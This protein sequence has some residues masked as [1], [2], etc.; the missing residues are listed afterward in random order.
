MDMTVNPTRK[1]YKSRRNRFID[2]ICGGLAE[3]F[4]VDPTI[5][6]LLWVL[7]TFL[8][9]SGIILYIV[10]MIL[11]P[12]NPEHLVTPRPSDSSSTTPSSDRRRFFG[13]LLM[14]CGI[15]FLVINLG[16]FADFSW[17][18]F[19]RSVMLPIFLILIGGLFIYT[20]ST[21]Q[22]QPVSANQQNIGMDATTS[23][24]PKQKELR[25]SITD[26]KLFGVCGGLAKYFNVDATI[27]RLVFV[28]MVLGSFG[29]ALLLY[30]IL[31]I[32]VQ[33]EKPTFTSL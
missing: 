17:W 27:V 13:V 28:F 10:G 16:W 8:G 19:S 7:V 11:M 15:F 5:V 1:L 12:V 9:G 24:F 14:L 26:R 2:G 18:S 25:R 33:E 23:E 22:R 20:Y 3:Y 6:R 4:E 21:K 29:W 30:I 31:G 32:I